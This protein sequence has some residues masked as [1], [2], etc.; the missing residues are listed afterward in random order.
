VADGRGGAIYDQQ[1]SIVLISQCDFL[2]NTAPSSGGGAVHLDR[3]YAGITVSDSI[4]NAAT[5]N[6][7]AIDVDGQE[8]TSYVV[9]ADLNFMLNDAKQYGGEQM[10]VL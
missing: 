10:I 8:G 9:T 4:G 1:E 5:G 3:L 6:G 7:G 2:Y